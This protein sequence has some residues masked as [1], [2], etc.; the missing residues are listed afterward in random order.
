MHRLPKRTIVFLV[1]W[2][3]S[4]FSVLTAEEK[5]ENPEKLGAV[6]FPISCTP[7]A[8]QQFNRAVAM[9]HSFWYPQDLNA[10][11]EVTKT[12]PSCAMAYWGIAISRRGNPLIGAPEPSVLKDGLEAV[13][14]AKAAGGKTQRERDY[15]SAIEAYY[16]GFE[17]IDYRTRVLAY[18]HAM[19]QMYLHYPDDSEA[20]VFY[21]LAMDEAAT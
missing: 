19:E 16:G 7:A 18:E 14:K 11:A 13:E 15:I 20:A 3:F 2:S 1:L 10:F 9:L 4:P 17:K 8:Q 12:D 5:T 6:H 21:A